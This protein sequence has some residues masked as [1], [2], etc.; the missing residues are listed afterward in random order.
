MGLAQSVCQLSNLSLPLGS[1]LVL[2]LPSLSTCMAAHSSTEIVRSGV[3]SVVLTSWGRMLGFPLK[4][5]C[6]RGYRTQMLTKLEFHLA[7][8][9]EAQCTDIVGDCVAQVTVCWCVFMH[10]S[11]TT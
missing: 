1:C 8:L 6:R 9:S 4:Q 10:S 5:W 2:I 3:G 7:H 11:F